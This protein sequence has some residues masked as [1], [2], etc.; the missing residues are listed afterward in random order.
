MY[1]LIRTVILDLNAYVLSNKVLQRTLPREYPYNNIYGLFPLSIPRDT[2]RRLRSLS[3]TNYFTA[4]HSKDMRLLPI[5][6]DQQNLDETERRKKPILETEKPQ[7]RVIH[8][9][10]TSNEISY[11]C[12]RPSLFPTMYEDNLKALTNGYGYVFSHR[13]V[14]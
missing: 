2:I 9:L 8:H 6:P 5:Q 13:V 1:P 10:V 12:N 14:D 4:A 3:D 7:P 11:V